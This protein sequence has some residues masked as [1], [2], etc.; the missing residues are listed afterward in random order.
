MADVTLEDAYKEAQ[1]EL[2]LRKNVYPRWI[3]R[4]NL[5][6]E[7]AAHR[8]ACQELICRTLATLLEE[9]S[10]QERLF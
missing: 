9:S 3:A 1:R 10:P 5:S 2:R 6:P 8:L 7:T 4:E